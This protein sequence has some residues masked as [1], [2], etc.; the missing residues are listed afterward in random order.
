MKRFLIFCMSDYYPEG[1]WEDYTDSADTLEKVTEIAIRE[2]Q[3]NGNNR[4]QVVD[5]LNLKIVLEIADGK[6]VEN[7]D[8]LVDENG[9]LINYSKRYNGK[10]RTDGSVKTGWKVYNK[11]MRFEGLL[12]LDKVVLWDIDENTLEES[13]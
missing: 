10:L 1:G 8:E 7:E 2:S 12:S 5:L 13:R 6:V 4:G 9:F 3:A 11:D